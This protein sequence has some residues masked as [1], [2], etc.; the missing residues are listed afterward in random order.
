M[1]LIPRSF[2]P[3]FFK[4]AIR[5]DIPPGTSVHETIYLLHPDFDDRYPDSQWTTAWPLK[6]DW[7]GVDFSRID[8]RELDIALHRANYW[9]W[10]TGYEFPGGVDGWGIDMDVEWEDRYRR[11]FGFCCFLYNFKEH[12]LHPAFARLVWD[13]AR[14]FRYPALYN[15]LINVARKEVPE[16]NPQLRTKMKM[17]DCD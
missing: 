10:K 15:G 4:I 17:T 14:I 6:G 1:L 12:S 16:L 13:I 9:N 7:F 11:Y 5:H 3:K 8:W 2:P